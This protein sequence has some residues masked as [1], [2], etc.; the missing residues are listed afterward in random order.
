[1]RGRPEPSGRVEYGFVLDGD[2]EAARVGLKPR[3]RGAPLDVI[4]AE[5]MIL[6]NCR[7]GG[8]L[9][10]ERRVG[11]YRSQ[12]RLDGVN[13]VKMGTVAA[14]HDGIGVPQY[15]WSTSPLRRYVD[16]VNQRQLIAT[17]LG[18]SPPYAAQEADVYAVVSAFE[19]A[20][21][22]YAEFQSRLERYWCLRWLRQEDVRRVDATVLRGDV[23]RVE[24]LPLVT[25]VPGLPDLPRGRRVRFDVLSCDEVELSVE[26]R[27]HEIVADVAVLDDDLAD[28]ALEGAVA[29]VG[30]TEV[31]A[32]GVGDDAAGGT[33]GALAEPAGLP[34]VDPAD[35]VGAT[36]AADELQAGAAPPVLDAR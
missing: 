11:I 27:L 16:L 9:A 5:L 20:Y 3:T 26:L 7:W 32:G 4:V 36:E 8:W 34:L 24:G 17:A 29:G 35:A 22:S 13:R 25:R 23:I 30:V 19:A 6:A 18:E 12:T 21:A 14:P 31:P 10:R 28:E 2:G 33:D 15:A 1:V